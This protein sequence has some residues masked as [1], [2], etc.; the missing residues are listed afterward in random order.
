MNRY[1]ACPYF[2]CAESFS[3]D[4]WYEELDEHLHEK[5]DSEI[6]NMPLNF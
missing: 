5:H 6:E 1:Q 2:G 4:D 3:G